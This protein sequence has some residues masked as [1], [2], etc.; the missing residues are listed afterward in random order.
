MAETD[1]EEWD[2]AVYGSAH[3]HEPRDQAAYSAGTGPRQMTGL[4]TNSA[5]NRLTRIPGATHETKDIKG[6]RDGLLNG[7]QENTGTITN[8][9]KVFIHGGTNRKHVTKRFK[10]RTDRFIGDFHG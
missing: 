8:A 7:H 9:G 1:L 4:T 3:T 6:R 5:N 2:E 10:G